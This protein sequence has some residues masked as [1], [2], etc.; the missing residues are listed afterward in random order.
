MNKKQFISL[1]PE[2]LKESIKSKSCGFFI[3]A[4]ISVKSPSN[5]PGWKKLLSDFISFADNN[6]KLEGEI[7]EQLKESL[8]KG[9]LLEVAEFL[10]GKLK[11]DYTRFLKGIFDLHDLKPNEN[12]K[13]LARIE[14][15]LFITTNYDKLL[16]NC[17]IARSENP[18]VSTSKSSDKLEEIHRLSK[19]KKIL[20]VHGD[21]SESNS[22][23]LS[24]T[25]YM[26]ILDNQMLNVI[27]NSY[28]H[29]YSFVFLGCSMTD[30]DVLIFLKQIKSI[31]KGYSPTH[32]ALIRRG[33]I[34]AIDEYNYKT[35]YNIEFI[36]IN[37]HDEVTE[38]LKHTVNLQKEPKK[39]NCE[40]VLK[41]HSKLNY[42]EFLLQNIENIIKDDDTY[43]ESDYSYSSNLIA[44]DIK[45]Y[46]AIV[47]TFEEF[48][49]IDICNLISYSSENY[50]KLYK[51][52]YQLEKAALELV[53]CNIQSQKEILCETL[54]D[55]R[56]DIQEF[57]REAIV[58][59]RIKRIKINEEFP[60]ED[61]IYDQQLMLDLYNKQV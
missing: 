15:P 60:I 20:K 59:L 52:V 33:E 36:Y 42:L 17:M 48:E 39:S 30:P 10:Q 41:Q 21:I 57:I 7:I 37:N 43:Y 2:I 8:S 1:L 40:E 5:L 58:Y 6:H 47:G 50:L 46:R 19:R 54:N 44:E 53:S 25:D 51:K 27:L 35:I 13:L 38:F 14:S 49:T 45:F 56:D 29:R 28:F 3:G 23:V 31:F 11:E 9:K 12:H 16:E 55:T 24:E 34:N 18:I 26:G 22:L 32:Y 61:Y 4:G